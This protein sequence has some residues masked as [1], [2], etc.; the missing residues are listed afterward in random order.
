MSMGPGEGAFGGSSGHSIAPAANTCMRAEGVRR[1]RTRTCSISRLSRLEL[2][3]DA[4]KYRDTD[5]RADDDTGR[6]ATLVC[7]TA[8]TTRSRDFILNLRP[9][10]L[11][12]HADNRH[13][14]LLHKLAFESLSEARVF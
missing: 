10:G 9:W 2:I 14:N 1:V 4:A 13:A 6:A 12:L 8:V 11:D 7:A 3:A 5:N